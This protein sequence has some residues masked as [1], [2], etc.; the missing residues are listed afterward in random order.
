MGSI[1]STIPPPDA[2]ELAA[3]I[4]STFAELTPEVTS[5]PLELTAASSIASAEQESLLIRPVMPYAPGRAIQTK[6]RRK[7]AEQDHADKRRVVIRLAL[8][9]PDH[10]IDWPYLVT[11][12]RKRRESRGSRKITYRLSSKLTASP[13]YLI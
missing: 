8:S 10:L 1:P 6:A 5:V 3:V 13:L 11:L 12:P 7:T 9:L 2:D 4:L